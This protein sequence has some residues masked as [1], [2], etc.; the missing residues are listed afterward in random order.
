MQLERAELQGALGTFK[1]LYKIAI[2]Q[3]QVYKYS[4]EKRKHEKENL[5]EAIKELQS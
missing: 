5:R 3:C 2:E 1:N 4:L